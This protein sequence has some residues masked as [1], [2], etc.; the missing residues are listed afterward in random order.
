MV[1]HQTQREILFKGLPKSGI[2]AEIGV[3]FGHGSRLI[4][5]HAVPSRLHLI[6]PWVYNSSK[7]YELANWGG[8]AGS[9]KKLD[10]TFAYVNRTFK[11]RI[12]NKQVVIHRMTSDEAVKLFHKNYFDWIYVDGC[13]EYPQVKRDLENYYPLVRPG[14]YIC[15]DDYMPKAYK[16]PI[17]AVDEFIRNFP[18]RVC[19][20]PHGFIQFKLQ[21][22]R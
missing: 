18:V 12:E 17:P 7:R 1:L 3:M 15:G 4:L 19:K 14:G 5:K 6:D 13:H 10:Q 8:L 2:C 16:G 9:Q 21:K 20:L 11:K 22:M